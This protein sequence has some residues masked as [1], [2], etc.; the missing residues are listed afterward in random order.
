MRAG[1]LNKQRSLNPAVQD[2]DRSCIPCLGEFP[3]GDNIFG[4][5]PFEGELAVMVMHLDVGE[6]E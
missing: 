6:N 2:A 1:S 5:A 3:L 4:D